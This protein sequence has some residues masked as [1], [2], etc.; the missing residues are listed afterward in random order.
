M[1]NLQKQGNHMTDE[2]LK[3]LKQAIEL[4]VTSVSINELNNF[5]YVDGNGNI[6]ANGGVYNGKIS[7]IVL[8]TK[9][10]KLLTYTNIDT[11][12]ILSPTNINWNMQPEREDINQ[13][14]AIKT[15]I[16]NMGMKDIVK[17]MFK[18]SQ[19]FNRYLNA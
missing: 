11:Y 15:T 7:K 16:A 1:L 19:L 14:T 6:C 13:T 18:A 10:Q 5:A 8:G 17:F 3:E 9:S 12:D 2:E 4:G